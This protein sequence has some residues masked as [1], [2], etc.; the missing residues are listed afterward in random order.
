VAAN[1]VRSPTTGLAGDALAG[2]INEVGPA[3]RS[4]SPKEPSPAARVLLVEDDNDLRAYLTRLL[5]SD[6]WA[7]DAV[8]DA[9]SAIAVAF[10]RS[11]TD[12]PQVILSDVMLPGQSGLDL[13]ITMRN[14]ERT[15]RVPIILLTARA[16]AESAIEG[17]SHGADDYVTKPFSSAELLARVRVH[18][19]L[20]QLREDA[21]GEAQTRVAQ[22][23]AAL[24]SNRAIGTAVGMLISTLNLSAAEAFQVL[25]RASQNTNRKL[26]DLAGDVISAK[27]LP[28]PAEVVVDLVQQVTGASEPLLQH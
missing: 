28:F 23:R 27:S 17:L 9:E 25:V 24:D 11:G 16:G 2:P 18:H 3:T 7:V 6:G 8:A 14:A 22:L 13:L 20:N 12:L 4:A 1:P 19:E 10:N 21:V 15:A 26:R 5:E